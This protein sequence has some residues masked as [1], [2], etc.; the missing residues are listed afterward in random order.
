[1]L[2]LLYS[3][4]DTRIARVVLRW[5]DARAESR[6]AVRSAQV[7]RLATRTARATLEAP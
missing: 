2:L 5:C 4:D 3:F 1:M 6:L 7:H